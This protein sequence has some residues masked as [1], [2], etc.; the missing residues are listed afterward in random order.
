V[1]VP[2][3]KLFV[4]GTLGIVLIVLGFQLA[5]WIG[6][7]ILCVL[8]AWEAWALLNKI[9]NDTIS[10][11]I[12]DL[13]RVYPIIAVIMTAGYVALIAHGYIPATQK[14]LYLA[15]CISFLYGHF[16]FQRAG[17]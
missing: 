5:G 3:T 10:E 8:G 6:G 15:S 7:T 2:S 16:F 14:G 4:A 17:K 11:I 9:P 12:W 13:V 1:K